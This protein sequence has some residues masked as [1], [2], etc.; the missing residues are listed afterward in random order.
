MKRDSISYQAYQEMAH[1]YAHEINEKPYNAYYER[2]GIITLM[3]EVTDLRVLDAG[4]G[5]GFLCQWVIAHGAQEVIGVDFSENM[6]S[7]AQQNADHRQQFRIHDLNERMEFVDSGSID[8]V[9]SSLLLHYLNNIDA[10]FCEFYRVLR[11]GGKAVFSIHHPSMILEM[12][13]L[14]NYF[15][16]QLLT[17]WWNTPSGK[18]KVDHYHRPLR[19]Y[20]DAMRNAGFLI[21]MIEEPLPL[22]IVKD[23]N[24]R[25]YDL[26]STK[27]RFLFFRIV[28]P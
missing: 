17:D 1:Y 11:P 15:N 21:E 10:I 16:T 4:C 26:L 19:D 13:A 3:P 14:K 24:K 6:I 9:V 7:F 27:P 12:H 18:V 20:V 28:K 22:P 25:D 5:A 23:I 2:P 8:I